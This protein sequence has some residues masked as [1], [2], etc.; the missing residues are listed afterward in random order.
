M[1]QMKSDSD[2]KQGCRPGAHPDQVDA[3]GESGGPG[4]GRK[5][6]AKCCKSSVYAR[7]K[8]HR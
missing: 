3:S 8:Q 6:K 7:I 4:E 1:A 5:L 2:V